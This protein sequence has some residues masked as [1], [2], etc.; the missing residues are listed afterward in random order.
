MSGRAQVV[1]CKSIT[2]LVPGHINDSIRLLTPSY[3]IKSFILF[4]VTT[5]SQELRLWTNPMLT[6]L[7]LLKYRLLEDF[8][9]VVTSNMLPRPNGLEQTHVWPLDFGKVW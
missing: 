6:H 3:K 8:I 7:Y 2:Q 5:W 1:L 9:A 4:T